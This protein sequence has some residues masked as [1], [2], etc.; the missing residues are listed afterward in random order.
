MSEFSSSF[1]ISVLIAGAFWTF[2]RWLPSEM[3]SLDLRIVLLTVTELTVVPLS[4]DIPAETLPVADD[5][6]AAT[7]GLS[8]TMPKGVIDGTTYAAPLFMPDEGSWLDASPDGLTFTRQELIPVPSGGPFDEPVS[9]VGVDVG[10]FW[11]VDEDDG[12]FRSEDALTWLPVDLP[13][14]GWFDVFHSIDRMIRN[15][16]TILIEGLVNMDRD[17]GREDP[18]IFVSIDAGRS[19]VAMRPF[20]NARSLA[21]GWTGTEYFAVAHVNQGVAVSYSQDAVTWS[22]PTPVA[23]LDDSDAYFISH[24]Q[25]TVGDR[26]TFAVD[27]R[28]GLRAFRFSL[29]P[30]GPRIEE[31]YRLGA[32]ALPRS[33]RERGSVWPP[34][35]G[36]GTFTFILNGVGAGKGSRTYTT[37]GD[38]AWA[39]TESEGGTWSIG[40]RLYQADRRGEWRVAPASELAP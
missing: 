11:L 1:A 20:V 30:T 40:D 6:W 8:T 31:L 17:S 35:A 5:T 34:H 26:S 3:M 2:R 27:D 9:M 28:I 32:D 12:F 22:A 15:G 24:V 10:L 33:A 25:S 4:S 38:G 23:A 13:E 36:E 7:D 29:A 39:V 14:N 16:D 18:A 37:A 21:T 19:F